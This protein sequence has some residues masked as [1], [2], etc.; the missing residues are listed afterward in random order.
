MS[1]TKPKRLIDINGYVIVEPE[2]YH[3]SLRWSKEMIVQMELDNVDRSD[4]LVILN[5][6]NEEMRFQLVMMEDRDVGN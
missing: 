3:E 2:H 4:M 6:L 1:I 5:R